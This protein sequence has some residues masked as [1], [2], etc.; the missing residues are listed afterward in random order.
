VYRT[1][2]NRSI[3]SETVCIFGGNAADL[4]LLLSEKEA[5]I[6]YI[7]VLQLESASRNC[8]DAEEGKL[9][10]LRRAREAG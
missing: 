1:L 2:A 10:P 8:E 4:G 5:A 6:S 7:I 3:G 9:P